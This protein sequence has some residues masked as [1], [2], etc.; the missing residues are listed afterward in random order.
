VGVYGYC[1][2]PRDH[3]PPAA[4]SGMS[5]TAVRHHALASLAV[6]V[7]EIDR[8]DPTIEHIE[9]HNRVVEAAITEAVTPVPL[10][11]G[12]WAADMSVLDAAINEKAHWYR[13]R[14]STFQGALEFGLRVIRPDRA[15]SARLVRPPLAP[16]GREYMNSLRDSV[17]AAHEQR[18]DEARIRAGIT[19]ELGRFV[20]EDRI[21]EGRTPHGVVTVS[22]LVARADFDAYRAQAHQLRLRF[23]ELRFLLSGPWA[24]YSFAG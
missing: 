19:E 12:Q 5:Q 9:A 10:R 20:R 15:R 14:L 4:L 3:A 23:S 8:P 7:A 16:T 22:H 18:A 6:W 17:A 13:E 2:V 11:F 21:E 24:P 1:V